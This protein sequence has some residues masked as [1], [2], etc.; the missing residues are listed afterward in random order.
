MGEFQSVNHKK[1][2]EYLFLNLAYLLKESGEKIQFGEP[3][4]SSPD[5]G[6]SITMFRVD[7]KAYDLAVE[8]FNILGKDPIL[9]AAT[10]K[11]NKN[12]HLK[13]QRQSYT[14]S[15]WLGI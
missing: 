11:C 10:R 9:L 3:Q 8:C 6:F 14:F 1:L 12:S 5:I 13:M 2:Q 7:H 15:N 4:Y